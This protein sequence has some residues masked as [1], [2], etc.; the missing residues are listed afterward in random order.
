M[1]VNDTSKEYLN[2]L[3]NRGLYVILD[4]PDLD[5]MLLHSTDSEKGNYS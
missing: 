2:L 5:F 1:L 3:K 4:M